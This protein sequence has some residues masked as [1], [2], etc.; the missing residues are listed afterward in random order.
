MDPQK[1]LMRILTTIDS[2]WLIVVQPANSNWTSQ[3]TYEA[4]ASLLPKQSV[5][6]VPMSLYSIA[7]KYNGPLE[8]AHTFIDDDRYD[9][10]E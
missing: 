2:I 10:V 5:C 7:A 1:R 9:M 8:A 3:I 4:V 6:A